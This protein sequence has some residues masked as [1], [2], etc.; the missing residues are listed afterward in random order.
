MRGIL[1]RGERGQLGR[2]RLVARADDG[3]GHARLLEHPR[4][5]VAPQRTARRGGVRAVRLDLVAALSERVAP[6]KVVRLERA[7]VE[8]VRE[9]PLASGAQAKIPIP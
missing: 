8:A 4:D 7:H 5:R 6:A 1:I 3:G 2:F 9:E